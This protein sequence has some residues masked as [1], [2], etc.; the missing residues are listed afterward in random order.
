MSLKGGFGMR[1]TCKALLVL[2]L[3]ILLAGPALAQGQGRRGGGRGGMGGPGGLI[4]NKSVQTELKLTEEQVKKAA[5]AVGA[6]RKKHSEDFQALQDL[7]GDERRQKQQELTKTVSEETSKAL[8]DILTADQVKRLK[9]ITLQTR[10]SQAFTDAEIQTALKLTDDQKDKVKTINDD[11]REEM[12]GLFG[13]G[14]DP[15]ENMKKM[16]AM[17]KEA[18]DKTVAVLTD[19]QKKSWTEMSGKPFELK[20]E[21]GQFGRRGKKKDGV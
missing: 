2:G 20:I 13:G 12:R 8:G 11:F 5:E 18:M 14:G 21:P 7:Q 1:T 19:D 10:G 6:V 9:E 4:A 3:A 16:T 17:R 15:Q